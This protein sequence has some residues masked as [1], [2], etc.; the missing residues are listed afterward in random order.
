MPDAPANPT[1]SLAERLRGV[2]VQ[3]RGE[4]D[5]SRHVFR[6]GPAYV[7]RDPVTFATHR[8]DPEDYRLLGALRSDHTL[9]EI[10][11]RLVSHGEI[12]REEEEDFYAF[13]LDL[14]QR[15]LL[16]LPVNNADALYQRFEKRRRAER[17]SKLLGVLFLRVPLV[18]P[19]RF[20]SRTIGLTRWLFT[21][22]AFIP[23]AVL[24]SA[25]AIASS[26]T[27]AIPSL[28][29]ESTNMCAAPMS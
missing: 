2:V 15:S 25:S 23:W 29:L 16:T 19:D 26:A 21:L 1:P 8:F 17:L 3:V 20:L 9:G 13:I 11:D 12:T 18:N 22:P 5:I 7:V 4:L 6:D 28:R 27:L 14:H 24:R 10:F